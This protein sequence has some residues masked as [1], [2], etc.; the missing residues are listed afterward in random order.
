MI[1]G[2]TE[3]FL[4][5]NCYCLRYVP[6]WVLKKLK[7]LEIKKIKDLKIGIGIEKKQ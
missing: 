5:H 7:K 3:S 1:N 6:K 4:L 2:K